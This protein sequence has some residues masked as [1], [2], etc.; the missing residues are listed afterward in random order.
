MDGDLGEAAKGKAVA[1]VLDADLDV[2]RGAV[3]AAPGALPV[4]AT[5]RRG[6]HRLGRGAAF[7][8][9]SQPAAQDPGRSRASRR[10][11]GHWPYRSRTLSL[12]PASQCSANDIAAVSITLGRPAALDPFSELKETGT[13]LL[14]DALT[15]ATLAAGLW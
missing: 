5:E 8:C 3:L 6:A 11:Q 2:A 13:F 4:R 14:V 12:K 9:R 15:G 7:R 1:L 10:D